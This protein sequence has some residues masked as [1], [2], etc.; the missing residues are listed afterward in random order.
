M[1]TDKARGF[2]RI[3]DEVINLANVLRVERGKSQGTQTVLIYFVGDQRSQSQ[4]TDQEAAAIWEKFCALA[5][6][7]VLP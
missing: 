6:N 3:G 1:D 2:I 7:W 4:Y 5:E